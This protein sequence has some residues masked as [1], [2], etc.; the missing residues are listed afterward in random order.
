MKFAF[1]SSIYEIIVS[2][3]I[4]PK[5]VHKLKLPYIQYEIYSRKSQNY[6]VYKICWGKFRKNSILDM[7]EINICSFVCNYLTFKTY[8]FCILFLT[9]ENLSFNYTSICLCRANSRKNR[10]HII[11]GACIK[12]S[13][14]DRYFYLCTTHII[15]CQFIKLIV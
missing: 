8:A 14:S 3:K 13:S 10:K 12:T 7:V 4:Y 15:Y 11:N 6:L 1:K 9:R 5:H 2:F